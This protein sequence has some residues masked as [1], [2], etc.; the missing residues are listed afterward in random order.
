M[1][2]FESI[3]D[4]FAVDMNR[5]LVHGYKT[6]L[7]SALLQLDSVKNKYLSVFEKN[8]E[9]PML[10]KALLRFQLLAMAAPGGTADDILQKYEEIIASGEF[11]FGE[12]LEQAELALGL[13]RDRFPSDL[14]KLYT[15]VCKAVEPKFHSRS[16]FD[17]F[18]ERLKNQFLS[19]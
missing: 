3:E 7:R 18:T 5:A 8:S 15:E 12:I 9:I 2:W 10:E 16:E 1:T 14:N 13:C 6:N 11:S 19:R 17:E 4:E